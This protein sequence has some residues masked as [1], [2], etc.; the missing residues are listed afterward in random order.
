MA[1]D[2]LRVWRASSHLMSFAS[3]ATIARAGFKFNLHARCCSSASTVVASATATTDRRRRGASSTNTSDRES[4]RAIR[5][6][7]V[8]LSLS[9]CSFLLYLKTLRSGL[10]STSNRSSKNIKD[11]HF[12]EAKVITSQYLSQ[13]STWVDDIVY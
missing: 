4:V 10:K 2:A 6:K 11:I 12:D 1:M 8:P 3:R 9:V 13:T 5:L 7:K